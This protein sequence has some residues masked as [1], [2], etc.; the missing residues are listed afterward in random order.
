MNEPKVSFTFLQGLTVNL[1]IL[2]TSDLSWPK[3]LLETTYDMSNDLS[4]H[5]QQLMA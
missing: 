4:N 5:P 2:P 3:D 1:L